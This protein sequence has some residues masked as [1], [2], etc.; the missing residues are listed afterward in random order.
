MA[1]WRE[2]ALDYHRRGRPGKLEIRITKPCST[3]RDLSLAYSP[4]VA[5]PVR[6][7]ADN[8]EDAFQYTAKGNLVAV[9]SNGTAVLGLGNVGPLAAKPVMEGKGVLFK[10]FADIDVFDLE[11]DS[12][13]PDEFV[14]VVRA[15]APS[16]GGINLEDIK[17][18]ECFEI[19][20][21]LRETLDI[22]VFHDDQ[23]GTAIIAG[24]ALINALEIAGKDLTSVKVVINGAGASG[25][26]CARFFVELGLPRENL[27]LCDS[28]GVVRTSR[29]EGMNR[30]K[31]AFAQETDLMTL[32]EAMRGAD[33]FVGLSVAGVVT[34][35]MVESMA[36]R[37][38][39]FALANPDPEIP[40]DVVKSVRPD[41][42]VATG[43]SDF[44][45][46]VNN[47]L[48]FPF[49]FRGALDVRATAINEAMKV[50]AARALA[51]LARQPV[52]DAVLRAYGLD[53]LAFGPDY[54]IPKP[55]D[56][57][58]LL[59]VAPAVAQ[60]AMETGVA[61]RSIDLA[62]YRQ[63]L[64]ARFGKARELRRLIMH[65]AATSPRRVVFAEGEEPRIIRAAAIVQQEGIGHPI[66]LGRP[67]AV[68]AKARELGVPVDLAVVDPATHPRLAE[69]ADHY[70]RLRQRRG[71]TLHEA[72]RRVLE[73][74]YF[75]C[76]MVKLG[77]A[78]AFVAGLTSH[79]P[80]VI[81]PA[82]EVFRTRPGVSRVAG[83]YIM[84]IRDRVYFFTDATVNIEPTSEE[85]AEI[86]VMAAEKVRQ[87]GIE[88]RIAMLSFSNFG[89]TR[90]PLAEKV[91]RAVELVK[92]QRPDLMVDGEMQADTA[93]VP[94][95]LEQDYPFS[96][97]KGGANVLVFPDLEAANIA[98]KLLA[99]LGGAE[100]MG[101]ILMGLNGPVHVLQ[102][103][104]GVEDIVNIAA[105]AV[106]DAQEPGNER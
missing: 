60:A 24:A 93:V 86:A 54:I 69:F 17:A 94:E 63:R 9:I 81:R 72:R 103:G 26:A 80:D 25:I 66:L 59:W 10:R 45:N 91:R 23:H 22:P 43:R 104:D 35:E 76:L 78:D 50:S 67:D 4:G 62:E 49:I 87:L 5:E 12:A 97:L 77:D 29:R 6:A 39:V 1:V 106:M 44:P 40:Y 42:I 85:L 31:S 16:F 99:R 27:W 90:H 41:A 92:A 53:R 28:Q 11:I 32:A 95:I 58:V 2:E 71:V 13:D 105:V 3:Q 21:R 47:V 89:S 101:P 64:E 55:V 30:Y 83:M 7:I 48:G 79:Y 74:N 46:Q 34:P 18:P 36:D 57:R 56:P 68:R 33:V 15:V 8:P 37:P 19:E 102:R 65:K 98:Y 84:T 88:P 73:P 52:P 61:R 96:E 20:E 75:G 82:L 38:I 70:Y 51:Q 100:A 14:R